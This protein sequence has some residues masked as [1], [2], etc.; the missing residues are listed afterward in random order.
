MAN[1]VLKICFLGITESPSHNRQISNA[2]GKCSTSYVLKHFRKWVKISERWTVSK[3]KS[4]SNVRVRFEYKDFWREDI[5][6]G[7]LVN[8]TKTRTSATL[9]V[10]SWGGR[11][12]LSVSNIFVAL[13]SNSRGNRAGVFCGGENSPR[14]SNQ[15]S[16]HRPSFSIVSTTVPTVSF[17]TG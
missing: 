12:Y 13:S 17:D 1:L 2:S 3:V 4:N 5:W 7:R 14:D 16:S 11:N 6:H 8:I 9:R 15:V 10:A